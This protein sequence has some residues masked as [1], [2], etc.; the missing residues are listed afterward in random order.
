MYQSLRASGAAH[1]GSGIDVLLDRLGKVEGALGRFQSAPAEALPKAERGA[2]AAPEFVTRLEMAKA[3]ED[4][5]RRME[6]TVW[7]HL[8]RQ[9]LAIGSLREMILDT[10]TLLER[11]LERLE[12][13]TPG[14]PEHN[15]DDDSPLVPLKE[16]IARRAVEDTPE[17]KDPVRT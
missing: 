5:E 12:S 14:D 16:P 4:I 17:R 15:R 2:R 9:M 8:G 11:V 6:K 13:M 7:E 3:L 10:D 1:R